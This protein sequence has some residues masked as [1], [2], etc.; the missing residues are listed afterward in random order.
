MS[1]MVQGTDSRVAMMKLKKTEKV[2]GRHR[3]MVKFPKN[4]DAPFCIVEGEDE[5]YYE[6]RVKMR[7]DNIEPICIPCGGKKKVIDTYKWIT[8]KTEYS[9]GKIM[10]FIDRDFDELYNDSL[11]YETPYYSIENFYTTD[12]A[13]SKIFRNTFKFDEFGDHY[14]IA[15]DLFKKRQKEFHDSTKLFNAWIMCQR[16]ISATQGKSR[17]NLADVSIENYVSINLNSVTAKYT[18][19]TI[20][21]KFPEAHEVSAEEL[22]NK[23]QE[24]EGCVYQ[25]TFRGKFE[26]QFLRKFLELLQTDVCSKEPKHFPSKIKVS[27]NMYDLVAQFSNYA[28]TP[29]C[30]IDYIDNIWSPEKAA[31]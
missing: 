31:V 4:K 18:I 16:D 7:C 25:E 11:I 12:E 15:M 28:T 9:K 13:I 5:K 17:L 29:N 10:Y 1:N 6:L 22:N 20:Q 14:R 2:V 3:F 24:L 23:L 19:E 30:L 26:T 21:D 27:L 8:K